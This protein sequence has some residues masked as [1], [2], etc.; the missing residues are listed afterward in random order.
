[1]LQN[2]VNRALYRFSRL[3]SF[4]AAS[5]QFVIL[6]LGVS[7]MGDYR[8]PYRLLIQ[9]LCRCRAPNPATVFEASV[10][11]N[12]NLSIGRAAGEELA[13]PLGKLIHILAV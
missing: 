9:I 5:Q 11:G 3:P 7:N 10:F 6:C 8:Q 13:Y 12:H 2:P 4:I 1:L